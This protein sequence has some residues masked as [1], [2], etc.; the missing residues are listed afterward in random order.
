MTE[1]AAD[2]K[3]LPRKTIRRKSVLSA[4]KIPALPVVYPSK[5]VNEIS[6]ANKKEIPFEKWIMPPQPEGYL[7][8]PGH[9]FFLAICG[10][11]FFISL[12]ANPGTR[13]IAN[14]CW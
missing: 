1:Y 14:S 9:D 4:I 5:K 3:I 7:K 11:R 13:I 8:C 12:P 2:I 10:K 6:K